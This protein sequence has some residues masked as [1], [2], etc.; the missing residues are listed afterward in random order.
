MPEFARYPMVMAHPNAKKAETKAVPVKNEVTGRVIVD[1][2]GTPDLLPPVTVNNE[3]QEEQYLAKGYQPQGRLDPAAFAKAHAAPQP[4]Q[5][6]PQPYPKWVNGQIV[7]N[8]E[9][10]MALATPRGA[11]IAA[12]EIVEP[13]IAIALVGKKPR[14]NAWETR[15]KNLAVKKAAQD[16]ADKAARAMAKTAEEATESTL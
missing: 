15:R 8:K 7:Q 3:D 10:E 2:Y 6:H 5:Y 16:A 4:A 14:K 11:A 13:R 12:L 1:H 9:E